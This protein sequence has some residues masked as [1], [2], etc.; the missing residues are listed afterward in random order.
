VSGN[1]LEQL[2]LFN[3][4][5]FGSVVPGLTLSSATDSATIRGV[6]F[7]P[8]TQTT[9]T[10]S[11][12]LNDAPVQPTFAFESLF[13]VGQI[14]L[15]RG[16]QG[17][18]RGQSAPSGAIT[19]T[20]R[21]P[22]LQN[23]G[24]Y[25][26]ATATDQQ[27]YNFQGAVNLPIVEDKFGLRLAALHD[28]TN[29]GGVDSVNSTTEPSFDTVAYRISARLEPIDALSVQVA[30]QNLYTKSI[31]FGSGAL[32][33]PGNGVQGPPLPQGKLL[34]VATDADHTFSR[35]E[36]LSDQVQYRFA[37]QE[38][39]YVGGL[40]KVSNPEP[41]TFGNTDNRVNGN[42]PGIAIQ[43]DLTRWTHELRL[44]SQ[45]RL[46]GF[47]D[48]VAGTY[49]QMENITN[50]VN[51]GPLIFFPGAFGSPLANPVSQSPN[52]D[53]SLGLVDSVPSHTNE[54]SF[55]GNGIIHVG[56]KIEL[57][58]G[59]RFIK[60]EKS[61]TRVN[62]TT[63]ALIALALPQAFCGGLGG[64][65]GLTYPGVCSIPIPGSTTSGP[66]ENYT[67][68]PIVYS[69]TL[70]YHFTPDLM[71]YFN[72]GSAWRPGP[73]QGMFVNGGNDPVLNSLSNLQDETSRSYEV[74]LKST[75]FDHRLRVNTDY[76]HQTFDNFVAQIS[77]QLAYLAVPAVGPPVVDVVQG[78]NVNVPV[79]VDGVDLDVYFSPTKA[80]S[81]GGGFSWAD[82]RYNNALVPCNDGNFDGI[83]DTIIPTVAQFQAHNE[84]IAQC[85]LSGS[86]SN[87]PKWDAT[88]QSQFTQPINNTLEAYISG[89]FTY[90]P[91][92]PNASTTYT[93]P[94]YALLNLYLGVR[95]PGTGWE[96]QGY[97]KNVTNN[98]TITNLGASPVQTAIDR[99][100]PYST[101]FG[102][103]GYYGISYLPQREFG[104]T[105]RYAV[106]SR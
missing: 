32:F 54:L 89:L 3:F 74:G 102:P 87:A 28:H 101:F 29:N 5:D 26:S 95:N 99:S 96:I 56:E 50:N 63:P 14:E 75:W 62:T 72:T 59:V 10:V 52:L 76:Y 2:A 80:W 23:F 45:E 25:M 30:Y 49:Y 20:S 47:L 43:T 7:N 70:S 81:V 35:Q 73:P 53:Y 41:E 11:F 92:N 86:S 55:F 15:L 61:D 90:N 17:T 6:S 60:A 12:Y 21:R 66:S 48:Y 69:A 98:R 68:R 36:F 38:L 85:R 16:P 34:T 37:G 58:G 71:A 4:Q 1:A 44:S 104:V 105:F 18:L 33:G 82:G 40:S 103:S 97:A 67:K 51:L 13:D 64:T 65:F 91:K 100:P 42:W 94:A 84:V 31:A 88:L 24:G 8:V 46:F 77:G 19:I 83:P 9:P 106:G 22:D 39:T 79:T 93:V 27:A 57:S 78:V